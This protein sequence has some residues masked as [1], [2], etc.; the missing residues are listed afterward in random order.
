MKLPT[1]DEFIARASKKFPHNSWVREPGFTALYVRVSQRWIE[2]E[3][4]T[5][6][7]LASIEAKRPG[8]GVFTKLVTRL[9]SQYPE[10]GLFVES[11]LTERFEQG[12]SRM[13]FKLHGITTNDCPSYYLLPEVR[14]NEKTAAVNS[15]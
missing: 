15:P 12:L 9:R 1:L 2:G 7:D 6:I 14:T 3:R 13:G 10:F 4:R 11:I 8:R 5:M